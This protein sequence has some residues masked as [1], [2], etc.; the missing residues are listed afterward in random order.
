MENKNCGKRV[1]ALRAKL[2]LNQDDIADACGVSRQSVG[3]WE[4][5]KAIPSRASLITLCTTFGVP[6]E[7]FSVPDIKAALEILDGCDFGSKQAEDLPPETAATE[8]APPPE[9]KP[10]K[11]S[12]KGL[13]IALIVCA[14]IFVAMIVWLIV[15]IIDSQK[16]YTMASSVTIQLTYLETLIILISI[17]ALAAGIILAVLLHK[18]G[19]KK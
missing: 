19:R 11:K 15:K 18:K 1:C 5:G 16:Y 10:K 2:G 14:V 4:R 3:K 12:H 6:Y 13:I 7:Y 17:G 9:E 8:I